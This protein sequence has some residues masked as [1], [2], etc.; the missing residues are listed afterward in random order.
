MNRVIVQKI[1]QD[2]APINGATMGLFTENDVTIDEDG[3]YTLKEG[4]VPIEATRVRR[5]PFPKQ[6]VMLSTL[7]VL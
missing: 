7:R 5:E 4:A 1:D 3:G 6:M 2:G